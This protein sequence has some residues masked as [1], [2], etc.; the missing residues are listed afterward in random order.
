M[1]L[2][3]IL[4]ICVLQSHACIRP[5]KTQNPRLCY[6]NLDCKNGEICHL[7]ADTRGGFCKMEPQKPTH[8]VCIHD[9]D[10]NMNEEC[11]SWNGAFIGGLCRPK[12]VS[13]GPN[14]TKI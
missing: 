10:C 5:P 11:Y 13:S 1:K 8:T 4:F 6:G 7:K 9:G 2:A 14:M 3:L 12:C